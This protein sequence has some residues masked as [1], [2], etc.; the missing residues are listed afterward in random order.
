MSITSCSD[1]RSRR[2]HHRCAFL[3]TR[4]CAGS[5]ILPFSRYAGCAA[6]L[7]SLYYSSHICCW[8]RQTQEHQSIASRQLLVSVMFELRIQTTVEVDVTTSTVSNNMLIQI[9]GLQCHTA[10]FSWKVAFESEQQ[11]YEMILCAC[12]PREE[13]QWKTSI[14]EC[15]GKEDQRQIEDQAISLPL[16]TFLGLGVKPLGQVFGLPGTL[17][18]RLSVQRASTMS[19]RNA[20]CQVIIKNTNA[21]KDS[22]DP[23]KSP[24]SSLGR[25]QSHLTMNRVS[26][27]APK[28]S[29]RA[30]MEHQ[31]A[32]VWTK[33][34]LP[35]PGMAGHRGENM[36]RSSASS[37]IRK[38]SKAS[39]SGQFSKRSGSVSSVTSSKT[40]TASSVLSGGNV[41][42]MPT[43]RPRLYG[44]KSLDV[45]GM[46]NGAVAGPR[47]P[48]PPKRASSRIIGKRS[49]SKTVGTGLQK[50]IPSSRVGDNINPERPVAP[51]PPLSPARAH[52]P[53]GLLKAFS[54][55]NIRGWFNTNGAASDR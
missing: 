35:Y 32:G 24:S 38:L 4:S 6:T 10:L 5:C 37:V 33:E 45:L 31:L 51:Q 13:E 17:A 49:R 46:K 34:L 16:Y 43:S 48:Q 15:A 11:L 40:E 19:P 21:L 52:R 2:Y 22:R 47:H 26:M 29:E 18:R 23:Q 27:L 3:A 8:P 50:D 42:D 30:R 55:E 53:T 9:L 1:Y 7:C 39:I 54:T 14:L 28:R 44:S 20:T 36:I 25:S 41:D 12:S